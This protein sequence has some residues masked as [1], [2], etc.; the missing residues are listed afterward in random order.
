MCIG[1]VQKHLHFKG[2][3]LLPQ[4]KIMMDKVSRTG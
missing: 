2:Y 3:N 1:Q 4:L